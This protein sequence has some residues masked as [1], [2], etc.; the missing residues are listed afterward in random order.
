MRVLDYLSEHS[1]E[2]AA[3]DPSLSSDMFKLLLLKKCNYLYELIM[4]DIPERS[5][6]AFM[7]EFMTKYRLFNKLPS[8]SL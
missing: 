7:E 5:L 2:D 1:L 3:T 4:V 8:N 6:Q